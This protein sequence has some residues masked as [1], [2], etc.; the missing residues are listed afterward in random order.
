MILF[1]RE[2]HTSGL[3][4]CE[5]SDCERSCGCGEGGRRP[6]L[7]CCHLSS[8]VALGCVPREKLCD[9]GYAQSTQTWTAHSPIP[10]ETKNRALVINSWHFLGVST[11][12][13][14]LRIPEPQQIESTHLTKSTTE[15][16]IP[17]WH[18]PCGAS[19]LGK[20]EPDVLPCLKQILLLF[21]FSLQ[22]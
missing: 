22:L 16:R 19:V 18:K 6:L 5:D 3:L 1:L 20:C 11:P 13:I 8:V 12:A 14:S 4:F 9:T 15:K 7:F 17:L 21:T 2:H 10:G